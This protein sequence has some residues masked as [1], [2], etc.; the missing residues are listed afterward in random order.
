VNPIF[1]DVGLREKEKPG[2]KHGTVQKNL[3]CQSADRED[4]VV[5]RPETPRRASS[6]D[7]V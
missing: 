5:P 1:E 6:G 3:C 2:M 7:T 4:L